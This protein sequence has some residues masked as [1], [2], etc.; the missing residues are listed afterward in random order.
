MPLSE[1]EQR[2]LDEIES[3]LYADDPKFA[4]TVRRN[5]SSPTVAS[6]LWMYLLGGLVG[7][8]VLI[9]GLAFGPKPGGFPVISLI[10]FLIMFSA[11]VG[12]L[13]RSGRGSGVR[14][15]ASS[16]GTSPRS[17]ASRRFGSSHSPS[18]GSFSNRMEERFRRRFDG[19]Q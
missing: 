16:S 15:A 3:G 6:T 4:S 18:S 10:G 11:G 17:G 8:V 13:R 7:L 9:G 2:V 1:H 5:A 19:E 14:S 12:A